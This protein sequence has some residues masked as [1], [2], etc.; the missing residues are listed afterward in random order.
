M[1]SALSWRENAIPAP[2]DTL[3]FDTT[4]VGF[5]GTAAAFAPTNDLP[6]LANVN[7]IND[8]SSAGDFALGGNSIGMR[9]TQGTAIY[10]SVAVGTRATVANPLT[11]NASTGF[12]SS[13]GTLTLSWLIG[14]AFPV[15]AV[16]PPNGIV[17]LTG[18]NTR[19]LLGR[20]TARPT[21]TRSGTRWSG[22]G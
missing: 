3:I 21:S 11:L 2:G 14:G 8:A 18:A 10:S 9:T 13:L 6:A 19:S 17:E 22:G 16:S 1:G 7:I 5:A 15:T 12:G 20:T 4:T